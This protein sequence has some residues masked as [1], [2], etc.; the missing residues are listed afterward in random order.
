[1][2]VPYTGTSSWC[3]TAVVPFCALVT[4]RVVELLPCVIADTNTIS[5]PN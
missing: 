2:S 3:E 5:D 1:M 4:V